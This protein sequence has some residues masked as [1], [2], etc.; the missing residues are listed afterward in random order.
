M[1]LNVPAGA[2]TIDAR[3][4]VAQYEFPSANARVGASWTPTPPGYATTGMAWLSG[5]ASA[6]SGTTFTIRATQG[7]A[8]YWGRSAVVVEGRDVEDVIVTMRRGASLRGRIVW[9]T[10]VKL[11]Q[12]QGFAA[13]L[14]EPTDGNVAPA[15]STGGPGRPTDGTFTIDG[16][17][18][19]SY[20]LR[21][22]TPANWVVKSI[23]WKGRDYTNVPFDASS[24]ADLN[25]VVVTM[26]DKVGRITGTARD[27]QGAVAGGSLVIAFPVERE[28]W[29]SYG[30]NPTR[31]RAVAADSA[32]AYRFTNLPA[33]DYFVMAIDHAD[34][35]ADANAWRDPAFLDSA[36]QFAER[37]PLEWGETKTLNLRIVRMR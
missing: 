5:P 17:L 22:M 15:L 3:R 34:A 19:T 30:I 14:A 36:H 20:S 10:E 16:L 6:P 28:Q 8:A 33:G 29:A 25:G 37:V 2:Y 23:T 12:A 32:G 27:A 18:P 26:T 21:P 31:M 24:G 7:T 1:F 4:A 9:E 13:V 11:Q 35:G